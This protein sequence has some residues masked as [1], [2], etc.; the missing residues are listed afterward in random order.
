MVELTIS[1]SSLMLLGVGSATW[2]MAQIRKGFSG[3][4]RIPAGMSM[5]VE[6]FGSGGRK[7]KGRRESRWEFGRKRNG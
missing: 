3:E 7:G 1:V 5:V 4:A 6:V 2:K